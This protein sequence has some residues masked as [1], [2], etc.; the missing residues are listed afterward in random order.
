MRAVNRKAVVLVAVLIVLGLVRAGYFFVVATVDEVRCRR[1]PRVLQPTVV[2]SSEL[3]AESWSARTTAEV[4]PPDPHVSPHVGNV[5]NGPPG[6][7]ADIDAGGVVRSGHQQPCG[8][9]PRT[10]RGSIEG[11]LLSRI[12]EDWANV[13]DKGT[14]LYVEKQCCG[15]LDLDDELPF[16]VVVSQDVDGLEQQSIQLFNFLF[17]PGVVYG[18]SNYVVCGDECSGLEFSMVI[19]LPF[20][21][22][23][24][25]VQTSMGQQVWT[26]WIV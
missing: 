7:K 12:V 24:R 5:P 2:G 13:F 18:Y 3:S 9:G 25:V 1:E 11:Q 8:S 10:L 22:L 23:L 20:T 4:L 19:D 15:R 21:K 16:D 14:P 17:V 6:C 26:L